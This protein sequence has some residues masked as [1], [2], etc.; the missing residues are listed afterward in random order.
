MPT[1]MWEIIKTV[2]KYPLYPLLVNVY[3]VLYI[4]QLNL[5]QVR[6]ADAVDYLL[7]SSASMAILIAAAHALPRPFGAVVSAVCFFAFVYLILPIQIMFEPGGEP[8][9]L[10]HLIWIGFFIYVT[11]LVFARKGRFASR[12]HVAYNI[13]TLAAIIWACGSI[14]VEDWRAV[15]RDTALTLNGIAAT[16]PIAATERTEPTAQIRPNIVH[17]VLDGYSRADVMLKAYGYDNS[18]FLKALRQRGFEIASQSTAPYNQT[19]LSLGA[20]FQGGYFN[21]GQL[22]GLNDGDAQFRRRLLDNVTQGPV[23]NILA[24]R[25]YRFFATSIGMTGFYQYPD[26]TILLSDT[27]QRNRWTFEQTLMSDRFA[28]AIPGLGRWVAWNNFQQMNRDLRYGFDFSNFRD[29]IKA[30]AASGAPIHLYQHALAPHPPFAI[31][32]KGKD[33]KAWLPYT[34]FI[35]TGNAVIH[36]DEAR[37]QHYLDGHLEKVK[38]INRAILA[39]IDQVVAEIPEPRVIILQSDHGGSV[40]YHHNKLERGCAWERYSNL[41]AIQTR[42]EIP[43]IKNGVYNTVN[44][45]RDL[46]S[47]YFKLPTPALPAQSYFA[48]WDQMRQ[49]QAVDLS[50]REPCGPN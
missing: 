10:S 20:T 4:Y 12:F 46:F 22:A 13:L 24:Q 3:F 49:F 11:V 26:D 34:R 48:D 15:P 30:A 19:H 45:Y 42:P 32:A 1:R 18:K 44:I 29:Q 5:F 6:L 37:R 23:H 41:F 50:A 7:L 17:I 43:V 40:F 14:L 8:R 16:T 39:Y 36:G 31:T 47:A 25:G 2:G 35:A 21:A 9:L 27:K 28:N 38:Y 33:T